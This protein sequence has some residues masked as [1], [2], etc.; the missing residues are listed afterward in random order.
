[1]AGIIARQNSGIEQV[2]ADTPIAVS[3]RNNHQL[4]RILGIARPP[5]DYW[6]NY[7]ASDIKVTVL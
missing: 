2:I 6:Q 4:C 5:A 3:V 1:M 7:A